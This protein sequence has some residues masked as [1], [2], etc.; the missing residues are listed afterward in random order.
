LWLYLKG[1]VGECIGFLKKFRE[2]KKRDIGNTT[3][4]GW[5]KSSLKEDLK[6][7]KFASLPK[8][9]QKIKDDLGVKDD[10]WH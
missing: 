1:N 7:L 9:L 6:N 3:L 8:I 4:L 10:Q 2:F 5:Y